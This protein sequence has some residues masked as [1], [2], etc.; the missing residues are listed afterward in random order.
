MNININNYESWFI[1]HSENNLSSD[2]VA[3]LLLFLEKNP[4]LKEEFEMLDDIV[5]L[6]SVDYTYSE[7][8]ELKHILDKGEEDQELIIAFLE[9]DLSESARKDFEVRLAGDEI[10]QRKLEHFKALSLQPKTIEIDKMLLKKISSNE[11]DLFFAAYQEGGLS[12]AQKEQVEQYV[13]DHPGTKKDLK[14][15]SMLSLKADESIVFPNKAS[16]KKKRGV[17]IQMYGWISVAAAAVILFLFFFPTKDIPEVLLEQTA[18]VQ[19]LIEEGIIKEEF[20]QL[21]ME[22]EHPKDEIIVSSVFDETI[23]VSE[24]PALQI[25]KTVVP[26]LKK[27]EQKVFE[28][29]TLVADNSDDGEKE[30]SGEKQEDQQSKQKGDPKVAIGE[31]E[32]DNVF[33]AAKKKEEEI[34]SDL[35]ASVSEVESGNNTFH[36]LDLIERAGENTKLFDFESNHKSTAYVRETKF[37]MGKFSVTRKTKRRSRS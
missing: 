5:Y 7:K 26:K 3:E 11:Q 25:E 28:K 15:F 37:S 23:E 6:P 32:E 18:T 29:P 8:T 31:L 4:D 16:L 21:D 30:I 17:F 34:D 12:A 20:A 19:P 36:I 27:K 33:I 1:D 10:L 22:M 9:N 14:A 2:Q 35:I 13:I 24:E